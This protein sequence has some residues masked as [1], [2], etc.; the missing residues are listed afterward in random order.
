[1]KNLFD[2]VA[3]KFAGD[4]DDVMQKGSYVRG[5]LFVDLAKKRI[6]SGG[7]VLDYGCGPGRLSLLLAQEGFRV[8]GVDTS[9][10]MVEQ[11][12]LLDQKGLNVEFEQI[13]QFNEALPPNT[14][15]AIVCSSVIEY[16]AN[17]DELLQGFHRALRES[18][19]LIISYANEA[20]YWRKR[21]KRDTA[22]NPMGESQHHLWDWKSFE[23]LL[24]RNGF[25]TTTPPKYFESPW[26][27]RP[28]GKWFR[29]S[30]YVGSLGVVAARAVPLPA[31]PTGGS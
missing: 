22:V 31:S 1:M 4:I 28:W 21:W 24:T 17:A 13:G 25:G 8:R 20:S 26:E 15:D 3:K 29:N 14:Y 16:V 6:P 19:V 11:A 30:S 9:A 2:E 5:E 7:Y 12:R 27:G 23:T 10:G 18:G